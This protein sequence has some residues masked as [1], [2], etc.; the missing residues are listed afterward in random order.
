MIHGSVDAG[1]EA[2]M[3]LTV[4]GQESFPAFQVDKELAPHLV[5]TANTH[6]VNPWLCLDLWYF[7]T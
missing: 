6:S 1:S 2:S 5:S 4:L 3:F 7:S